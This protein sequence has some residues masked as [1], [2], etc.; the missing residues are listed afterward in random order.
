LVHLESEERQE[1]LVLKGFK[2][3][4]VKVDQLVFKGQLERKG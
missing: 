1:V 4:T 2:E 3:S